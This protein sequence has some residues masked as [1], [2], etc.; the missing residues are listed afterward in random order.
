MLSVRVAR[1]GRWKP[2]SSFRPSPGSRGPYGPGRG[3]I[4]PRSSVTRERPA[5]TAS[6]GC[7]AGEARHGYTER[8]GAGRA[9]PEEELDQLGP[10]RADETSK[11]QHLTC[12]TLERNRLPDARPQ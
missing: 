7:P 8:P 2:V 3:P 4:L 10:P 9:D 6:A 12:L 1:L 11:A 5:A